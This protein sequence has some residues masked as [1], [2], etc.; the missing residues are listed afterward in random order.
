MTKRTTKKPKGEFLPRKDYR[1]DYASNFISGLTGGFIAQTLSNLSHNLDWKRALLSVTLHDSG[2]IEV[3]GRWVEW[4]RQHF[5]LQW[6]F[7]LLSPPPLQA[8]H[9]AVD[10]G[11][12]AHHLD[13]DRQGRVSTAKEYDYVSRFPPLSENGRERMN[14]IKDLY[15]VT[16]KGK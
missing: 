8:R 2:H 1:P 5:G 6:L 13:V 11:V 16:P 12:Y 15:R 14:R 3:Q 9:S 10:P 4:L 7:R